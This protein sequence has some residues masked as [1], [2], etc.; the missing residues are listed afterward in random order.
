MQ[1]TQHSLQWEVI[2]WNCF[3]FIQEV[4]SWTCAETRTLV[5]I[6]LVATWPSCLAD[7]DSGCFKSAVEKWKHILCWHPPK[8]QQTTRTAVFTS[9]GF[10]ACIFRRLSFLTVLID[11][12]YVLFYELIQAMNLNLEKNFMILVTLFSI[13]L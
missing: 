5:T 1:N 12:S 13:N 9:N 7:L 6:C 8:L 4:E 3:S 11:G 2:K 10:N